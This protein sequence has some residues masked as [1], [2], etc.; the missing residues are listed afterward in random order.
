MRNK[1][2]LEA[3][4]DTTKFIGA[5]A[6]A[7]EGKICGPVAGSIGSYVFQV[8]GRDTGSYYTEDDAALYVAQK[9]QYNT[10]MLLS[11][12]MN[13]ADVKITFAIFI[14]VY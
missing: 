6:N 14:I 7:P 11:V 12:M 8:K 3:G 9:N 1:A 5:I 4:L 10:Q 13:D 2:T